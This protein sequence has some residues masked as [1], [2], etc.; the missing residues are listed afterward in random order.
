MKI[1]RRLAATTLLSTV[2]A[3]VLLAGCS[4]APQIR[5][6]QDP[7][8]DLRSYRNFAFFAPLSTDGPRFGSLLSGH[9]MRATRSQLEQRNYAYDD[10]APDFAIDFRVD[11]AATPEYH[12]NTSGGAWRLRGGSATIDTNY[13]LEGALHIAIVDVRR[14]SI[15]WHGVAANKLSDEVMRNPGPIV[16]QAVQQIL[17]GLP[18]R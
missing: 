17:A 3:S 18:A 4:S 5:H 10:S 9:L 16:E 13:Q 14:Q 12:A 1:T 6:D 7:T 15:V 2:A 11:L 8:A